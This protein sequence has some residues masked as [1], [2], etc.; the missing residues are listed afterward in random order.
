MQ[1]IAGTYYDLYYDP[2]YDFDQPGVI[3]DPREVLFVSESKRAYMRRRID[4]IVKSIKRD[5]IRNPAYVEIRPKGTILHPGQTRCRALRRLGITTMPALIVDLVGDYDGPGFP[6]SPCKAEHL[7]VD[8]LKLTIKEDGHLR[9][10]TVHPLFKG[11]EQDAAMEIT[12]SGDGVK[13]HPVWY[14]NYAGENKA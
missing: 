9:L 5:G 7:F 3:T 1:I 6:I 14:K 13:P 4:K 12:H 11:E 10:A 2:E 8:D